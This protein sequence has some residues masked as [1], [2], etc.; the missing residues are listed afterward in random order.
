V[1]AAESRGFEVVVINYRGL[2]GVELATPKLYNSMAYKDIQEPMKHIYDKYCKDFNRQVFGI[3][4]SM[5]GNI[6]GNMLGF[7]GQEC[8]LTAACIVAAPMKKRFCEDAIR[9]NLY[10][11]WDYALAL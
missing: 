11:F 6:L 9:N 3:G 10:G 1:L 2:N 4:C 7:E 8:Y 5:G